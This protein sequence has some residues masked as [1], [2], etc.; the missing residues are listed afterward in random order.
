MFNHD[1]LL[2]FATIWRV[3]VPSNCAHQVP[4]GTELALNS[5]D[6]PALARSVG[7]ASVD[8]SVGTIDSA[9]LLLASFSL[10]P[11]IRAHRCA[12]GP[13]SY[14]WAF[15][16][17]SLNLRRGRELRRLRSQLFACPFSR[18]RRLGPYASIMWLPRLEI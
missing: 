11:S 9:W 1:P 17:V 2:P 14:A 16:R 6:G 8:D 5:S 3:P 13:P 7:W 15:L 4:E 10:F 12:D 18:W